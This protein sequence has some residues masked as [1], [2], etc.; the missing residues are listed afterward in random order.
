MQKEALNLKSEL[1]TARAEIEPSYIARNIFRAGAVLTKQ[2]T[3]K[4]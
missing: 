1:L 2:E 4:L 3:D